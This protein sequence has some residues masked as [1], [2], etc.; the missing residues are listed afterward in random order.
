MTRRPAARVHEILLLSRMS[1]RPC[2]PYG[3]APPSRGPGCL[4]ERERGLDVRLE[5]AALGEFPDF[6]QLVVVGLDGVAHRGHAQRFGAVLR[7]LRLVRP[8]GHKTLRYPT[9]K[10][11]QT[12]GNTYRQKYSTLPKFGNGVCIAQ[13]GPWKRGVSRSSRRGPDGGGRGSR[14]RDQVLQGGQP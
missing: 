9:G 12:W 4:F 8:T 11:R 10:T 3:R 2:R 13:P 7:R 1:A 5:L 14:R 6:C